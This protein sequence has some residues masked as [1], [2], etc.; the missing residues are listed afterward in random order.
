[1]SVEQAQR[2]LGSVRL[3]GRKR[4]HMLEPFVRSSRFTVLP[5]K[6]QTPHPVG[7]RRLGGGRPGCRNAKR[8]ARSFFSIRYVIQN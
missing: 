2:V 3:C 8:D 6:N 4:R 5:M 1:M 7:S